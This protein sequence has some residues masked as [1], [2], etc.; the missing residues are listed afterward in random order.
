MADSGIYWV[1]VIFNICVKFLYD[2]AT[3]LGITYEEI[4]V[5]LFCVIWPI[6]T[7]YMSYEIIKLRLRIARLSKQTNFG[8][9]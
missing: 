9:L 1:D 6:V 5:W 2:A 4:N 3:T 7:I 8:N